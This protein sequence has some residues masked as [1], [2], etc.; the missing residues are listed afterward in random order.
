M[1][2]AGKLG[3]VRELIRRRARP[4]PRGMLPRHGDLPGQWHEGTAREVSAA[5]GISVPS[6]DS[7]PGLA[8]DLQARL[9]GT[10]AALAAGAISVLKARLIPAFSGDAKRAE[11]ARDKIRAA[12]QFARRGPASP[13]MLAWL[14]AVEAE[15]ETRFGDTRKALQLIRHAEEIF[16]T[17]ESRRRPPGWTGSRP[18]G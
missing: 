9:P 10:G 3:A 17:G 5:L 18:C 2:A 16:A 1:A 12:R 8:W 13:E 4:G 7:L 11:E 14:D 6:A 15:T